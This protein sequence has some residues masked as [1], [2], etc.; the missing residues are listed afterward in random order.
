MTIFLVALLAMSCL[1]NRSSRAARA[2]ISALGLVALLSALTVVGPASAVTCGRTGRAPVVA[3]VSYSGAYAYDAELLDDIALLSGNVAR[4][5]IVSPVSED[6]RRGARL[7]RQIAEALRYDEPLLLRVSRAG[8]ATN[9]PEVTT[10]IAPKIAK[11]MGKRGWTPDLID[12]TIQNPARKVSTTDTRW[13]PDGTKM[14]D[15]ATAY[16]DKNG[17]YVVRNNKTV[18]IVQVS[19]RN[20]PNWKSPF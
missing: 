9:T 14:N 7:S 5:V 6:G 11:Q 16:I 10:N 3:A 8:V 1:L 19:D 18:D 20:D 12:E 17:N 13:K 15:P 4:T 2:A